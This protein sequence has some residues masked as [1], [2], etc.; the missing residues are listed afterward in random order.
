MSS[1]K[2]YTQEEWQTLMDVPMLVGAAVMVVGKSGLGTMKESFEIARQTLGALKAYPDNELIQGI[3]ESRLKDK[4]KSS[5]ES[6]SSPLLKLQPPEFK[7]EVVKICRQANTLL[8]EKSTPEEAGEYKDWVKQI[9]DKV[10]H[11][12]SEGGILGFG[13]VEF[14]E[15]EKLAIDEIHAALNIA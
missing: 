15:E 5:I 3:L 6:F 14:S 10:A 9:A 7:E 1:K 4:E 8:A 2:D 12:A 11:A 13:G